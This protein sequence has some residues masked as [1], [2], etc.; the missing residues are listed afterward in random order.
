MLR[1]FGWPAL[2]ARSERAMDAEILIL[3]HQVA[4][5]Q[6]QAGEERGRRMGQETRPRSSTILPGCRCP[7]Q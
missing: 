7:P 4:V 3:R 6:R 5:L 2:L 1:L